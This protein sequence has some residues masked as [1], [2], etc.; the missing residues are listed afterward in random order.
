MSRSNPYTTLHLSGT[1]TMR[2]V[3]LALPTAS[4]RELLPNGIDLGKQELTPE[5]THPVMLGFH[6]MFRLHTSVP[7][8]LPSMTYH[9]H[10]VGVPYCYV[11]QPELGYRS[12]GPYFF[13]PMV[14]LDHLLA[15]IG[16]LVFWGFAKRLAR[17]SN[18]DRQYAVSGMNGEPIVG[19]DRL[20]EP[21]RNVVVLPGLVDDA[22]DH[23]RRAAL[24]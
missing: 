23:V 20:Q 16:G 24:R 19:M 2:Y 3:T 10:S 17:I 9:E 5:G 13:M 7:S 22:W 1:G 6:D 8:L 15:T 12:P 11:N 14:L 21:L 4:V 18:T